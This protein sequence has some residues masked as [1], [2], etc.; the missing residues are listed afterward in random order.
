MAEEKQYGWYSAKAAEIY[1]TIFYF[2]PEGKE[3]EVTGVGPKD[4][5]KRYLW[6]D[7]TCVGEVA[8]Y[9]RP[10][11]KGSDESIRKR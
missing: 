3:V 11:K 2:T 9:S 4:Y 10:G 1:G 6:D 7:V 8:R 5:H